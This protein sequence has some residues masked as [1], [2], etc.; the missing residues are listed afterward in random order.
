MFPFMPDEVFSSWIGGLID[1]QGWPF[2]SVDE[3]VHL[4]DWS[5]IFLELPLAHWAAIKWSH[6]TVD[7]IEDRL[8]QRSNRDL[9][10][11]KMHALPDISPAVMVIRN[12]KNRFEHARRHIEE[13]GTFPGYVVAYAEPGGLTV[14]DGHHRLAAWL[15]S[16][17]REQRVQCWIA[18]G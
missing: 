18:R 1:Q 2:S 7:G 8:S 13:W 6:E 3:P 9:M 12:T 10:Y 17:H 4:Q 16:P 5:R 14:V 15:T 11:L